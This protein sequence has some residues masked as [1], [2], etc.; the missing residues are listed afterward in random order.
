MMI[1]LLILMTSLHK[2]NIFGKWGLEFLKL[3][4]NCDLILED[5]S[6]NT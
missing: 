1:R 3:N 2:I 5:N 4:V 6:N